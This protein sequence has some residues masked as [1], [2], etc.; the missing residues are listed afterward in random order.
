MTTPC[1]VCTS[2]CDGS[3]RVTMLRRLMVMV[4]RFSGGRKNS[5]FSSSRSSVANKANSCSLPAGAERC[6][7]RNGSAVSLARLNHS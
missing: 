7:I 3:M 5:T 4:S 2:C 6:G 1:N